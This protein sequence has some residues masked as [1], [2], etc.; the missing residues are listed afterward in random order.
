MTYDE[1]HDEYWADIVLSPG[2]YEYKFVCY[3]W[4]DQETVPEECN[5]GDGN[6][7]SNRLVVVPDDQEWIDTD[8]T[9]WSGC[10]VPDFCDIFD[11]VNKLHA[12]VLVDTSEY[13]FAT[14]EVRMFGAWWGW[15]S[16]GDGPVATWLEFWDPN[17][18]EET[19][20]G[21]V[22]HV[23][24]DD[25]PTEEMVYTWAIN[26]ETEMVQL[27]AGDDLSCTPYTDYSTYA[28]RAWHPDDCAPD[29]YEDYDP[30]EDG[31]GFI[32]LYGGCWEDDDQEVPDNATYLG[33]F[34]GHEYYAVGW[35]MAMNWEDANESAF[36]WGGYLATI[37]SPE[38]NEFLRSSIEYAGI[39]E[40]HYIGLY[41]QNMDGTG[42]SWITG[43]PLDY[44]NWEDGEP[45]DRDMKM[46]VSFG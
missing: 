36:A 43:E 16:T 1:Y 8:V 41:D 30:N 22:F 42:W 44:T 37:T 15:S 29:D 5:D 21:G 4:A 3:N 10:P 38:E 14:M 11:C 26:G 6:E 32:D 34:E 18:A 12:Y 19:G 9:P 25:I 7:F 24:F 27:L 35:D 2:S 13:D 31:C 17:D 23:Q 39:N 33:E 45:T 40:D 46:L 28:S 20:Q